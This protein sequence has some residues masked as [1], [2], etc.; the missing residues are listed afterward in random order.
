MGELECVANKKRSMIAKGTTANSEPSSAVTQEKVPQSKGTKILQKNNE[1]SSSEPTKIVETSKDRKV[2]EKNNEKV[3]I[4]D[5]TDI[6]EKPKSKR[7]A[8]DSSN[9]VSS[10]EQSVG[11]GKKAEENLNSQKVT[12][13]LKK[14][15]KDGSQLGETKAENK[16]ES[17]KLEEG[18]KK[19]MSNKAQMVKRLGTT[20]VVSS[21]TKRSS[22]PEKDS[23][24]KVK[25]KI[26][27]KKIISKSAV[28]LESVEQT[29]GVHLKSGENAS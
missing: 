22:K 25:K 2:D 3:E 26:V 24:R 1:L 28:K 10:Q 15:S 14:N 29:K 21:R 11:K 19:K 18:N 4:L 6:A 12:K 17:I 7:K 9:I 27:K 13:L 20:S 16:V 23:L 5:K 8:A